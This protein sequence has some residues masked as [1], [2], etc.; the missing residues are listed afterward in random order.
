MK[1]FL[2]GLMAALSFSLGQGALANPLQFEFEELA[3]GVW[4]GVRP[5]S[6]RFPVMGNT[7][8]VIGEEGV[9]V[10]DG[11]GMPVMAEQ[12]I[13]KIRSITDAPVTHV[14]ISH[15]HGDHNFGVYRFAEEFPNVQFV[16]QRFTD[17]AMN[18][19]KID[20]VSGYATFA[21]KTVPR[22]QERV[23]TGKEADGTPLSD[24][25][26]D[27]YAR[28]LEDADMFDAEFKRV[29]LQTPNVS[30]DKKMTIHLGPRTIELL[31]LGHGNT[32]GDIVM[33]LPDE[34]IVATGDIVVLPSPYAFNVPPR[35]WAQ[36]LE[37]IN[38]LNYETL[39]P[40][41]GEI[42]TDTDYVN[43]V[44]EAATSIADQRDALV[45][46]GLSAEEVQAQLDFSAFEQ[47]F[48]GDDPYVALHYDQWF[49]QPLRAA[50]MKE[51]SGEP[52]VKLEPR[53]SDTAE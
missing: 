32:E 1:R 38:A 37:N 31:Y 35:A 52:M 7:T 15:W 8:F 26:R 18:S 16:A 11:G 14:I 46:Q 25:D 29:R 22:F 24:L 48:T 43:L 47:R 9:V 36:T 23:D 12:I 49:E 40:G 4:A 45:A 50:A 30:F 41:H 3:P 17:A 39:V 44:I 51:L 2:V 28:I 27:L 20:Y 33:W 6:P 42:Q 19:N 5:D 21:E 10:F 53:K 34:K 13:E